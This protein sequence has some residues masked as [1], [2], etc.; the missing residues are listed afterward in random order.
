MPLIQEV[1]DVLKLVAEL[2]EV[3]QKRAA[4]W[5]RQVV[6]SREEFITMS[7]EERLVIERQRLANI[8]QMTG[9]LFGPGG[10]MAKA[11]SA[12]ENRKRRKG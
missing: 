8:R 6:M 3:D 12:V 1:K 4:M 2:P 9:K 10:K 11:L 7:A 5:L